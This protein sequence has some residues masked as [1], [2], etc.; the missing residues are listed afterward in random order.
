[1]IKLHNIGFLGR[2]CGHTKAESGFQQEDDVNGEVEENDLGI[3][4]CCDVGA[5]AAEFREKTLHIA[6]VYEGGK[7]GAEGLFGRGHINERRD[8]HIIDEILTHHPFAI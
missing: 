3:G 7:T 6:L 8:M 1:M 5:C 2:A 4:I